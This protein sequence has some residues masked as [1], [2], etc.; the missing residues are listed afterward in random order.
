MKFIIPQNYNRANKL[1]GFIDYSSAI[2]FVLWSIFI[3]CII[4]FI[5][6]SFYIKT[7][8]FI[9]LCLP[10]FIFCFNGFNQENII[11]F[12]SYFLKYIFSQKLYLYRKND[13]I[14]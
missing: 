5:F 14:M 7:F 9:I 12:L 4:N 10:I 6:N 2:F 1:L 3:F 13:C 8:L 11:S